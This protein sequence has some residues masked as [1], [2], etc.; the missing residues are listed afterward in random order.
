MECDPKVESWSKPF[1]W[2]L[3]GS[4]L[5]SHQRN[6]KTGCQSSLYYVEVCSSILNSVTHNDGF[7]QR[8][9]LYLLLRWPCDFFLWVHLCGEFGG[10]AYLNSTISASLEWSSFYCFLEDPGSVSSIHVRG[11]QQPV[12]PAPGIGFCLSCT[13]VSWRYTPNCFKAIY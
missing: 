3:F 13:P 1:L 4:G 5:L 11:S 9:L 7:S 6:P 10:L 12:T 8:V 2:S